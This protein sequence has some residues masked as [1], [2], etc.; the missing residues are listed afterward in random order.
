MGAEPVYVHFLADVSVVDGT[1]TL[2]ESMALD[3]LSSGNRSKDGIV[4]ALGTPLALSNYPNLSN[5]VFPTESKPSYL[6]ANE[7]DMTVADA[8]VVLA[9]TGYSLQWDEI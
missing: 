1:T 5:H 8:K 9:S 7:T 6:P 2:D 3:D 4:G